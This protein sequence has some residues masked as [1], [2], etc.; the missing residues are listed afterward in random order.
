MA[1]ATDSELEQLRLFS[2]DVGI[3]FQIADDLLDADSDEAASVLRIQAADDARN[4]AEALL[5]RA[6]SRID[7]LC[8]RAEPLRELARF[9]VRRRQ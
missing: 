8:E 1:G 4:E 7:E 2:E 9:A 6:L 5:D 3:A